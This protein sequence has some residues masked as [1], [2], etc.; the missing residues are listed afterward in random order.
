MDRR[1]RSMNAVF[2]KIPTLGSMHQPVC[3]HD[4]CM[5]CEVHS[6]NVSLQDIAS[7]Q[8]T[9]RVA[10]EVS[11]NRIA[12]EMRSWPWNGGWQPRNQEDSTFDVSPACVLIFLSFY[13]S[14]Y[15]CQYLFI[16]LQYLSIKLFISDPILLYPILSCPILSIVCLPASLSFYLSV[17]HKSPSPIDTFGRFEANVSSQSPAPATQNA[18]GASKSAK[19]ECFTVLKGFGFQRCFSLQLQISSSP[20]GQILCSHR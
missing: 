10:Q 11:Q 5:C 12:I 1:Q 7:S 6:K 16:Y 13:L 20:L 18:F 15:T 2:F 4:V 14:I 9:H 17:F 8:S 3:C 19:L